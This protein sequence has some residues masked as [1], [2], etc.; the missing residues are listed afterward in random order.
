MPADPEGQ[1]SLA[2]RVLFDRPVL[3]R[4]KRFVIER[5]IWDF[6]LSGIFRLEPRPMP[7]ELPDLEGKRALLAACGPGDATTGPAI[8]AAAEVAAFD[9]SPHFA[10]SC[11]RNHPSWQVYC[12]DLL[13]LPHEA[14]AFDVS[15]LYSSLHHVPTDASHVLGELARVSKERVVVVEGVVPERG[16]LRQLLLVWYRL[17]DGGHHYY[18][19]KELHGIV[20]GLGWR[21]QHEA[22]HGPI[23]H[24][25]LATLAPQGR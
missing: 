23:Q 10:R 2:E 16:L 20:E 18:T 13:K 17:V 25:W 5:V 7:A 15:I 9:L 12:G 21:V 1:R 19:L 8:D 24:M 22:L 11:A 4:I 6:V 14:D 3:Y